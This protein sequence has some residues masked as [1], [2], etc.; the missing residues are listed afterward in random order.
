MTDWP[1]LLLVAIDVLAVHRI[2]RLIT[3]DLIT[4]RPRWAI[5]RWA[6]L[7][8]DVIGGDADAVASTVGNSAQLDSMV[9]ADMVEDP[10]HVPK[11]AVLVRCLWCASFWVAIAAV[12]GHALAPAVWFPIAAVFAL[13][14]LSTLIA[15]LEQ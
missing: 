3:T 14:S 2:T 12:A 6:Y 15:G 8:S 13:S 7:R 10:D 5:I 9:D 11:L 1:L 4:I